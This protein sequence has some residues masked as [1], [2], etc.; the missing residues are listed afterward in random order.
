QVVSLIECFINGDLIPSV[1]LW[2]SSS[3]LFV[4]DGGHRLSVL[5]AWIED[6]Y[7]DGPTSQKY[8]GTSISKHQQKAADKTRK[9]IANSVGTYQHFKS[10]A[11]T[12][13]DPQVVSFLTRTLPIQWVKGNSDKAE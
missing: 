8:F 11:E 3:F 6:D 9:L 2:K 5:K 4:I 13:S 12:Q 10:K 1:I 7:G